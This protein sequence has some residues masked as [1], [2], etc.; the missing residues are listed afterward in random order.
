MVE[1]R[2]KKIAFATPEAV[3]FVKS[4]GLADVAG[5]LPRRLASM[6][7]TVRLFLPG[8]TYIDIDPDNL[9]RNDI[10]L[11]V[12]L[13][14]RRYAVQCDRMLE[15]NLPFEY[16]FLRN[17]DF[18]DRGGLYVDPDTGEDYPDN[19]RRFA[20]FCKAVCRVLQRI[21]WNPDIV[22]ANDWQCG[23]LPVYLKTIYADERLFAGAKSV[24]T[25]HNLAYQG[26]F[27]KEAFSALGLPDDLSY[28][29]GPFEFWGKIN[30]LKSAIIFADRINTVS[31]TYA[32][33]IQQT[34]EFGCGL[35]G[36]LRD[37]RDVLSGIVNGVD[38]DAW[39]P[40]TDSLIPH[41]YMM[42]NLSGKRAN[43]VD[44]VN[45]LQLPLREKSLLVGM[46]S[47]LVD[48][49]G[50]DILF[51]V[52]DRLLELDLQLVVLG[53]GDDRYHAL[54]TELERTYPNK[55]RALLRFD[56]EMAHWIEA[57]ADAFLMPSR[58]EPCGLNQLYSLK[59]G[60]VPIVRATG[61]LNDTVIDFDP[62]TK[63]GT[64]FVFKEYTGVALHSAVERAV[65]VFQKS[66]LWRKIVKQAMLQDFSW[67]QAALQ[68]DRLYD[69]A[70]KEES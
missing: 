45:R 55:V 51:E 60:T 24:L 37:R 25:I 65:A 47:R 32:A 28:I 56:N 8:Y 70:L 14:G 2:E 43:K 46:I 42:S 21:G 69:D 34:P 57:G 64:G 17:D 44:L 11:E 5:A 62:A 12:E 15:R 23:L 33:E 39:S 4:G 63:L 35:E 31:S 67:E 41:N 49:K 29:A 68:Y 3:P 58:F 22:H 59:Y 27:P 13:D 26:V 20:F 52:A 9:I 48:Q 38:Y 40:K 53:T 61:G 54:L 10:T 16:L 18:F 30:L 19:Y 50:L 36:V 7:H 66:R 1:L 6:G